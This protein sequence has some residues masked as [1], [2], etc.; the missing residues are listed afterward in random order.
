MKFRFKGTID[1]FIK[2][3]SIQRDKFNRENRTRGFE[4]VVY[5]RAGFIEIGVEK[6]KNGAGYWYK[7]PIVERNGY[8]ELDGEILP[9]SDTKMRWYEWIIF[10][11]I[12]VVIAIPLLFACIFTK[13]LPFSTAKKRK[14][15]LCAYLCDYLGCEEINE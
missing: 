6:G 2:N 11:L 15:R 7:S 1:D 13:S 5:L 14:K 4:L 3:Y 8:I 12:L 9:D 10:V